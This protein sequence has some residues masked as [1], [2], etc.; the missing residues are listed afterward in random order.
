MKEILIT[1]VII[2]FLVPGVDR[3]C[4]NGYLET[5]VDQVGLIKTDLTLAVPNL[6]RSELF[7]FIYCR[8]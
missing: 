7:L 4:I 3:G 8:K 1:Q 2:T 5:G 6:S